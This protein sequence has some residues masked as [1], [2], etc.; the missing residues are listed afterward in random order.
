MASTLAQLA[1]DQHEVGVVVRQCRLLKGIG[2]ADLGAIGVLLAPFQCLRRA[3]V[4]M[5]WY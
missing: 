3:K 5:S 1:Q 2:T 4:S